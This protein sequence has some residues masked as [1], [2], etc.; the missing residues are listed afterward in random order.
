MKVYVLVF[1]KQLPPAPK[2]LD[3]GRQIRLQRVEISLGTPPEVIILGSE[4]FPRGL[5]LIFNVDLK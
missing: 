5:I 1:P 4:R 2:I 3:F